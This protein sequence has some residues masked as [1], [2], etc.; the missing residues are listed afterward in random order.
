MKKLLN[1][2]IV[3]L[4]C[5]F[6]STAPAFAAQENNY[7]FDDDFNKI[8]IPIAYNVSKII[9]NIDDPNTY[10]KNPEDIFI[11]KDDNVFIVDTGNNRVIKLNS[12]LEL[13]KIYTGTPDKPFNS[14]KGV[15]ADS[16]GDLF[17]AD[18]ANLRIAHISKDGEFIEEFTKPKS[19]LLADTVTFDPTKLYV[20]STGFINIIK[21]QNFM[22]VD[23]YNNFKGYV[24]A[25]QIG[26]NLNTFLIRFFASKQQRMRLAKPEPEPYRNFVI[27]DDNMIYAVANTASNQIRK[28]N[29]V[30]TNIYPSKNYGEYYTDKD[31]KLK[32]TSFNDIAVD[33]NGIITVISGDNCK[34]YQYDDEGNILACFGGKGNLKGLFNDPKG[35]AINSKG[36][37]F[38]IDSANNNLQIFKPTQFISNVHTAVSLYANGK[39]AESGEIWSKVLKSDVNYLLAHKGIAKALFKENKFKEAMIEYDYAND[40]LGYSEAFSEYRHKLYRDNFVLTVFLIILIVVLL[41]FTLNKLLKLN[42]RFFDELILKINVRR[43]R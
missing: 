28:I 12:S 40:R 37:L 7:I 41:I 35:L 14:P 32:I 18:T 30:G 42:K 4:I 9:R 21:G 26:F 16:N 5:L 19:I 17:V 29:V 11:D 38:V 39:Y 8:P 24:G 13:V 6:L 33:K 1:S 25:T 31:D 34:I 43:N 36:D 10:F 15:Y 22:T 2:C 27:T 20:N 23:A 3:I